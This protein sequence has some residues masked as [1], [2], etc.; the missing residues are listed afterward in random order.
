MKVRYGDFT[1]TTH[2][3]SLGDAT[4]LEAP[5]YALVGPLLR[6]AWT[7]QRKLR[8]VSVRFSGVE[9]GGQQLE[10]FAQS[11][12]KRRRLAEVLDKLN[13][14]GRTAVVQHGHQLGVRKE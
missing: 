2:G 4:D 11:D 6:E 5:F 13:N 8:L 14:R 3:K 1:Q 10:M 12:E 7:Q 9:E